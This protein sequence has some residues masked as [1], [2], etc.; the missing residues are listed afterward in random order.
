MTNR[1][2][3]TSIMVSLFICGC[4]KVCEPG[5]TQICSCSSIQ[6]GVQ[7]CAN[8]GKGWG[9]CIGCS[10]LDTGA[11]PAI[12]Y[13]MDANSD[14]SLKDKSSHKDFKVDLKIKDITADK[15]ETIDI[16]P[17]VDSLMPADVAK[18]TDI[19]LPVDIMKPVDSAPDISQDIAFDVKPDLKTC[20]A[21]YMKAKGKVVIK[22]KP[23]YDLGVNLTLTTWVK[24]NNYSSQHPILDNGLSGSY[25]PS[26][27]LKVTTTGLVVFTIR[28]GI[29]SNKCNPQAIYTGKQKIP[30][31]KWTHLAVSYNGSVME[32]Y[33]NG[34][35]DQSIKSSIVNPYMPIHDLGLG[36]EEGPHPG[37]DG[38]LSDIQIWS[39][40]LNSTEIMQ[41]MKSSVSNSIGLVGQWKL[42]EG[43]GTTVNDT[44]SQ[45]NSGTITGT[46]WTPDSPRCF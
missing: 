34:K 7:N 18:I 32:G 23:I 36:R 8:N 31:N 15:N 4:D 35:L 19:S 21:L 9:R 37:L 43:T 11:N 25:C 46:M 44:S 5:E 17:T 38:L 39:R 29:G 42:N 41:A 13:G 10:K 3:A 33:V 24:L 1:I 20:W 16:N 45:N 12:D 2:I 26:Y 30:L 28:G 14:Y 22:N 40:T 6:K 27:G